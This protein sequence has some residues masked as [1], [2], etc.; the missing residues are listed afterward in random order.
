MSHKRTG[1]ENYREHLTGF[2]NHPR[3]KKGYGKIEI[4]FLKK[5]QY[6]TLG[7]SVCTCTFIM[8]HEIWA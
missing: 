7:V 4:T 1:S 3:S 5:K 8:R 6:L 2:T